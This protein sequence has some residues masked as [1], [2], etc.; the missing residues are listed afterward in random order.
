M[1]LS[2]TLNS[3]LLLTFALDKTCKSSSHRGRRSLP[4]VVAVVGV[5]IFLPEQVFLL[6]KGTPS[7]IREFYPTSHHSHLKRQERK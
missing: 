1:T 6:D 3:Y 5:S 7:I 4:R 2:L